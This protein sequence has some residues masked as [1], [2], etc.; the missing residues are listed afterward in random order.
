MSTSFCSNDNQGTFMIKLFLI[1][2]VLLQFFMFFLCL[3]AVFFKFSRVVQ[4]SSYSAKTTT[5][6]FFYFIVLLCPFSFCFQSVFSP[7]FFPA[8]YNNL[9]TRTTLNVSHSQETGDKKNSVHCCVIM[10]AQQPITL[11]NF[12]FL[13]YNK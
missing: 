1:F 8:L 6:V 7:L 9:C 10:H 4:S 12:Y 5:N 11:Q 2:V 13:Y 3:L